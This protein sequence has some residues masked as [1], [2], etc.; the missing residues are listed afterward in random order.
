MLSH[1]SSVP[2]SAPKVGSRVLA[3]GSSFIKQSAPDYG[4][5]QEKVLV[6]SSSVIELPAH[7]SFNEGSCF[8]MQIATVFA[9]FSAIGLPFDTKLGPA[10][11]KGLLVWGAGSSMGC[12]GVQVARAMGY[13]VFATASTKHHENIRSLGV[14]EVFDYASASV[15]QDVVSAAKSAGVTI[16]TAYIA[17]GDLAS[18]LEVVAAFGPG[19]KVASAPPLTPGSPTVDGV[20]AMFAKA[21]DGEGER[22]KHFEKV[23][24]VWLKEAL[25]KGSVV[26]SPK[27]KLVG[28]LDDVNKALDELTGGVS[29]LKLVVEVNKEE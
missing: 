19:G 7:M 6:S 10:D 13:T 25:E 29:G 14:S 17:T 22:E 8:P 3:F 20:E 26:P 9:G 27:I 15:V 28:G 23:F 18:C 16:R 21:P 1:G 4:A 24:G 2:S 12:G 11:K 5:L